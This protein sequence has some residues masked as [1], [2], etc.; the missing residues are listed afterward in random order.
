A[1]MVRRGSPYR[2]VLYA[3]LM[4]EDGAPRLVEFNARFGDP[5][6]QV[7]AIQAGPG[8]LDAILACT[9]GRLAGFTP[10][11]NAQPVLC[12]VLAAR[13]YPGRHAKGEAIGGLDAAAALPGVTIFHSGTRREDGRI[14]SNG[15]RVLTVCARADSLAE[16]RARA[17][18][19]IDRIDWPGG[20]C[21]R[22]IGWRALGW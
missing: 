15:G 12:V 20:F 3:G 4:I 1:E 9:E 10:G 6:A 18:A 21:R 13:G 11:W 7:L 17:Y 5:E 2:G 22:D 14:L 16:A 8:L 19:A